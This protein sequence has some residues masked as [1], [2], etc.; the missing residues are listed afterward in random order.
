MNEEQLAIWNARFNERY[1]RW[2]YSQT[3]LHLMDMT[4]KLRVFRRIEANKEKT[5]GT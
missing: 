2:W 4:T 1:S 5:K 3:G